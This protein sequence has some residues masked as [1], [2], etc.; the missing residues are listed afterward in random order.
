MMHPEDESAAVWDAPSAV[1]AAVEAAGPGQ[2]VLLADFGLRLAR[3]GHVTK[4]S[5]SVA[6][7]PEA[8]EAVRSVLAALAAQEAPGDALSREDG[9]EA[10]PNP[11]HASARFPQACGGRTRACLACGGTFEVNVHHAQAH[12]F[13][14]AACRSRHRHRAH[15][16]PETGTRALALPPPFGRVPTEETGTRQAH[17]R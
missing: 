11:P 3:L 5:V 4:I 1:R 13:C 17:R 14:S 16:G 2:N 8:A 6:G 9:S 10:A 7:G 12:K 15:A